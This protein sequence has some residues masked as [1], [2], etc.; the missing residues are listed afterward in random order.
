MSSD[1]KLHNLIVSARAGNE[2]AIAEMFQWYEQYL[3]LLARTTLAGEVKSRVS[4]S[5]VVQDTFMHAFAAFQQFRG[6]TTKELTAWLRSIL[7]SRIANVHEK[8]LLAARRDVRRELSLDAINNSLTK[9]SVGLESIIQD[10]LQKSPGTIVSE[11]ERLSVTSRAIEQLPSHYR[12]VIL[13]RHFDGLSFDDI[14]KQL[15]R[16]SGAVRMMWLRSIQQM[17]SFVASHES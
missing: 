17:R 5:D 6:S 1:P 10:Q 7:A 11:R 3:R 9:T 16:S 12:Q 13:L 8:H 4:V 14:G 2:T 15:G